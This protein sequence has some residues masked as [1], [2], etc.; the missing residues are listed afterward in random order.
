MGKGAHHKN[1]GV[2]AGHEVS[3]V[4]DG[5]DREGGANFHTA[6]RE[7]VGHWILNDLGKE[8]EE[9]QS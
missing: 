1:N 9:K 2:T 4:T 6:H 3:H 8:A 7:M 5:R